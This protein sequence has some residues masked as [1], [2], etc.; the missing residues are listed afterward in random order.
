MCFYVS[1]SCLCPCKWSLLRRQKGEVEFVLA[2]PFV[3]FFQAFDVPV[4]VLC[5]HGRG[6]T[7]PA[8]EKPGEKLKVRKNKQCEEVR[9]ESQAQR[10][11]VICLDSFIVG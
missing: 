9:V 4:L 7:S 2:S 10:A 11:V 1:N 5:S 6:A 3:E 8:S